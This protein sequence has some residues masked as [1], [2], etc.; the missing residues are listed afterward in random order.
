M[1]TP[2]RKVQLKVKEEG[3]GCEEEKRYGRGNQMEV[4]Q[5]REGCKR[6]MWKGKFR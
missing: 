3:D 6:E 2:E 4:V 5:E 1:K